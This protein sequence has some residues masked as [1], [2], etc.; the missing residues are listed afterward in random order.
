MEVTGQHIRDTQ[1]SLFEARD[2]VFLAR[3]RAIAADICR[4]QGS[5]SINEVRQRVDIPAGMHPSVLGAVFKSK[6]FKAIGFTEATHPQAHARVVR[7]YQLTNEGET[8]GQ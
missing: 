7:V 5:V 3:C 8:N 1:L 2:A 4:Q 6:K